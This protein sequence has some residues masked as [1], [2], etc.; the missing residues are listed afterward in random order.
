M[1]YAVSRPEIAMVST[2]RNIF[3]SYEIRI[4]VHSYFE[5]NVLK[6]KDTLSFD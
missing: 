5:G 6:E 4:T 2:P 3:G 1:L